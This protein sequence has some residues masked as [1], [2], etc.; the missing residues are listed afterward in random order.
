MNTKT[1]AALRSS[2]EQESKALEARLPEAVAEAPVSVA[3]VEAAPLRWLCPKPC[4]R[5]SKWR[6][7]RRRPRS[8]RSLWRRRSSRKLSRR[9][10][11][12]RAPSPPLPPRKP[13]LPGNQR[14][15]A[16]PRPLWRR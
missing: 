13:P 2:L 3:A 8:S 10:S 14:L 5:R 4:P 15:R 1:K 12:L 16:P 11:C 6:P 9:P 7:S